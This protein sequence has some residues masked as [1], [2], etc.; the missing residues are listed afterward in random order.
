MAD[1]ETPTFTET[2]TMTFA[3]WAAK[4]EAIKT[5]DEAAGAAHFPAPTAEPPATPPPISAF[6][7]YYGPAAEQKMDRGTL[8]LRVKAMMDALEPPAPPAEPPPTTP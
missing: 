1:P 3:E 2:E 6:A 4:D 5:A 8:E 7:K